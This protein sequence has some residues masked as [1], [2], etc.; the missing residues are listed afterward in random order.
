L[1]SEAVDSE[2]D[3]V[4]KV[5]RP[6]DL[7]LHEANLNTSKPNTSCDSDE[8]ATPRPTPQSSRENRLD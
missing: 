7:S 5:E 3:G 1:F 2:V 6:S 8:F 4:E